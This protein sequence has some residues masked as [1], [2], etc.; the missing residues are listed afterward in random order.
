MSSLT[1]HKASVNLR[2][3][4]V[5]IWASM[6]PSPDPILESS[7]HNSFKK[8]VG[9]PETQSDLFSSPDYYKLVS[10]STDHAG[11]GGGG[12]EDRFKL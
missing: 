9:Y 4:V 10:I 8:E 11:G 5:N 7:S 2:G 12:G 1:L 6:A 3:K